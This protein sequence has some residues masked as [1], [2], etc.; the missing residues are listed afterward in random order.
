MKKKLSRRS[1]SAT[2]QVN[3]EHTVGVYNDS[4]SDPNALYTSLVMSSQRSHRRSNSDSNIMS[5]NFIKGD[6]PFSMHIHRNHPFLSAHM[7]TP[8]YQQAACFFLANFVLIP[9]AGTMRGYLDFVLPLLKQNDPSPALQ[10]AFSAV[11][12]AALGTRPNSKSLLPK[13]DLWYLEALQEINVALKDPAV[14]SSD[15]TLAAVMLLAS[16]EVCRV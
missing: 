12:L 9:E 5:Q 13:A 10:H 8:I 16:F 4:F 11:A 14:A 7:T 15:S 2:D 1:S 6:N 3:E